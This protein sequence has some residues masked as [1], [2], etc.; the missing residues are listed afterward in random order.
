MTEVV[1]TFRH[2]LEEKVVVK[3]V[4]VARENWNS[5]A[6]VARHDQKT[7]QYDWQ[8]SEILICDKPYKEWLFDHDCKNDFM[9]RILGNMYKT[10]KVAREYV[11]R[12]LTD[13]FD[14]FIPQNSYDDDEWFYENIFRGLNS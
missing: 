10:K 13:A 4:K 7:V 11:I 9:D 12:E 3:C 1:T 2:L 6:V 14:N 8:I 5:D